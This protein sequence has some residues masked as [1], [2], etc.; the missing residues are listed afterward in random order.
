MSNQADDAGWDAV[1][2]M[3]EKTNQTTYAVRY[4]IDGSDNE[5]SYTGTMYIQAD[6]PRRVFHWEFGD[7]VRHFV[8]DGETEFDCQSGDGQPEVCWPRTEREFP[9]P[10]YGDLSHMASLFQSD[11][12]TDA[13]EVGGRTIAGRQARCF[14]LATAGPHNEF[15]AT[16]CVWEE[17]G[18]ILL[19]QGDLPNFHGVLQATE[20]SERVDPSAFTL[21]FAV[22]R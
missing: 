20:A 17:K 4:T 22:Q 6:A 8:F 3:G 5:G 21:P 12:S 15:E 7:V 18:V 19:L 13:S 1:A 14:R 10:P 9:P 11:G 2:R 16:L